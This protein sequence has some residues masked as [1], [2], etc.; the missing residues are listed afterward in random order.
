MGSS[1]RST[2]KFVKK[3]IEHPLVRIWRHFGPRRHRQIAILSVLMVISSFAEVLSIGAILPFLGVIANPEI[4]MQQQYVAWV[5][6]TFQ[7]ESAD[8]LLLVMAIGFIVTALVAA[9]FRMLQIWANTHL[10]N[11][12]GRDISVE[13][14]RRTLYQ[15]YQVHL[16]RN[17]SE[18]ISSVVTKADTAA[19]LL[20]QVLLVISTAVLAVAIL[21]A[22][23]IINPIVTLAAQIGFGLAYLL[24]SVIVRRQLVR[25]GER[26]AAAADQRIKALHEGLGGIRDVLLDG[27]QPFFTKYYEQ[28]D[29]PLRRSSAN[30]T[31][32]AYSPRYLMEAVGMVLISLL[33]YLLSRQDAGLSNTLPMLGALAVGAQRLLPALQQSYFAW[34]AITGNRALLIDVADMLDQPLPPDAS[35]P[36]PARLPFQQT[37]RFENVRFRYAADGPWVIDGFN[38]TVPQGSRVGFVGTTGGG[39]STALDLLMGLLEPTDGQIQVDGVPITGERRRAWQRAIAHVPQA[40]FL[41]DATLSEN[42]AFGVPLQ[43]I[44][45][46][47]VRHA[48]VQAQIAD[49]IESNPKGYSAMVGERGIRLSGGQRQRIGIAR[50]LYKQATVLIFDEATSALDNTTEQAVMG[51][52]ENLGRDLTIFIVAHRLTT[53]QRCDLIVEMEAGRVAALGSYAELLDSSPAFRL[54]AQRA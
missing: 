11:A 53:V 46:E 44:D 38:L 39:K 35:L 41:A 52:L 10:A 47:R 25:N 50:A 14:F 19:F 28:A 9:A 32:I 33:A 4:A 1:S 40:I 13:I 49:F 5:A 20:F 30:N 6:D 26:I 22:L 34:T 27:S 24:I 31:A 16:S 36:E 12:A 48:A 8:R 2:G 37:I 7:I 45:M 15:P 29:I 42:I 21:I 17:S 54:L 43:E 3:K 51:A 18:V 23:F